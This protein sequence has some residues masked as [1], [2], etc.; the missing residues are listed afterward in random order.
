MGRWA[1]ARKR[2]SSPIGYNAG[3]APVLSD[4]AD[5]DAGLEWTWAYADPEHWLIQNSVNG[6]DEWEDVFTVAGIV[7]NYPGPPAN[8]WYR[9]VGLDTLDVIITGWSNKA[10]VAP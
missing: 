3:A 5:P 6:I 7:R 2:G 10:F 9:M 4:N 8:F 1:Q